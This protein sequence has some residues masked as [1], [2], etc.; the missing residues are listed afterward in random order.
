M[1]IAQTRA[2]QVPPT[3]VM[4]TLVI[5]PIIELKEEEEATTTDDGL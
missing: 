1:Y 5:E 4:P 2:A 3:P